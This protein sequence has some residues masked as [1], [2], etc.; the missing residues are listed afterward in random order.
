LDK[1]DLFTGANITHTHAR[2][3]AVQEEYL[4]L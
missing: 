1:T 4:T 3:H 2:T